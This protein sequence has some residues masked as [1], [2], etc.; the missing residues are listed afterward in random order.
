MH[1]YVN[2]RRSCVFV[3]LL[4]T[5]HTY[6]CHVGGNDNND[7]NTLFAERHDDIDSQV[8]ANRSSQLAR[9]RREHMSFKCN[10]TRCVALHPRH[11][12]QAS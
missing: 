10:F 11:G 6:D 7:N 8:Q 1:A 4:V 5:L 2:D 3:L 9:N 12:E